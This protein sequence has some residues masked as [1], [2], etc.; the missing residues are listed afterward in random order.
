MLTRSKSL[1]PLATVVLACLACR[2]GS[3][4]LNFHDYDPRPVRVTHVRERHVHVCTRDCHEHYWND[5]ALVVISGH[6]HSSRCGHHWDGGRWVVVKR[7]NVRH[8]HDDHPRRVTKV[9]HIHNPSCGH[10]YHRHN[11]KWIKIKRSHAHKPGC[12][13]VYVE[14]RWTIRF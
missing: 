7:R 9:T 11:R 2:G 5:G 6:R 1:L 13:H 8:G 12:G 14:G 3:F 10:V 4:S